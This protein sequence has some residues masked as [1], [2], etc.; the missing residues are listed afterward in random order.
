MKKQEKDFSAAHAEGL[1][2]DLSREGCPECDLLPR[3]RGGNDLPS[4]LIQGW[5]DEYPEYIYV[6]IGYE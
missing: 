1:H 5:D 4:G 3:N 6:D 2:N